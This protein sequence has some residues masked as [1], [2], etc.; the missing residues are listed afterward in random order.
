M[1]LRPRSDT[2][3]PLRRLA[4]P[5]LVNVSTGLFNKA[6]AIVHGLKEHVSRDVNRNGVSAACIGNQN[7]SAIVFKFDCIGVNFRKHFA[8][9]PIGGIAVATRCFSMLCRAQVNNSETGKVTQ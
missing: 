3:Q 6:F 7:P 1:P 5:K 4:S 9:S 2:R 8:L